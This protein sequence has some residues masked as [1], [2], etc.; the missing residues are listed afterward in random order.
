MGRSEGEVGTGNPTVFWELIL[1]GGPDSR[2]Q[3]NLGSW[4][5]TISSGEE[6]IAM[7]L[8]IHR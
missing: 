8:Y 2:K 4:W 7:S 1:E 6:E 5:R 3:S